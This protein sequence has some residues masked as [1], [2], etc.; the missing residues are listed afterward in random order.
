ME[1]KY[2]RSPR[3]GWIS[4]KRKKSLKKPTASEQ[5]APSSLTKHFSFDWTKQTCERM[6]TD[7]TA[8][9]VQSIS[10]KLLANDTDFRQLSQ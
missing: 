8:S 6:T 5:R 4:S 3:K 2:T 9:N 1:K 10:A 7:G